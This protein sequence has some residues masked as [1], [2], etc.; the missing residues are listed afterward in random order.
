MT[1][2]TESATK[3]VRD[4]AEPV[5]AAVEENVRD[6]RRALLAGRH[7]FEDCAAEV[8]IQDANTFRCPSEHHSPTRQL[9]HST[10]YI[11]LWCLPLDPDPSSAVAIHATIAYATAA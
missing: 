5:I 3:T 7:A 6:V 11:G 4:Y 9:P 8:T 10:P 1:T 2:V